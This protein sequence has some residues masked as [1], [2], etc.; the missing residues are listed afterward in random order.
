MIRHGAKL[1]YAFAE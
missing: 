1:L